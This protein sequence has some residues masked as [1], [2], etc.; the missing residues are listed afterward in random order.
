M[1]RANPQVRADE[2]KLAI[3]RGPLVYC[4]E[5]QDNGKNLAS[6]YLRG[7]AVLEEKYDKEL[8]G[9]TVTVTAKAKRISQAPWE[10]GKL[11]AERPVTL[12]DTGN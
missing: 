1:V 8:F 3:M 7:D 11:Y 5:E 10:D 9:G 2:G 6:L 4:L 12:E